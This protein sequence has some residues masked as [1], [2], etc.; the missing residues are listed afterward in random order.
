MRLAAAAAVVDKCVA[1]S[2]PLPLTMV[3]LTLVL[4]AGAAGRHL[5]GKTGCCSL[6]ST[7]DGKTRARNCV[8]AQAQQPAEYRHRTH[9]RLG[10]SALCSPTAVPRLVR[11]VTSVYPNFG[12]QWHAASPDDHGSLVLGAAKARAAVT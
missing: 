1:P 3:D 4:T 5:L 9:S 11:C 10:P 7:A 2:D 8:C 6:L 12:H